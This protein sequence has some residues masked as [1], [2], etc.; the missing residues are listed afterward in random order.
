[1]CR[2]RLGPAPASFC[3]KSAVDRRPGSRNR[4]EVVVED[5]NDVRPRQDHPELEGELARVGVGA[6]F[7]VRNRGLR[8]SL[9]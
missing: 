3:C 5:A 9:Q 8:F 7:A 6:D 4:G 1:M 2:R